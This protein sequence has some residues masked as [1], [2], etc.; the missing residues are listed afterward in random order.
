MPPAC[1][2][3]Q[4][5]PGIDPVSNQTKPKMQKGIPQERQL[6]LPFDMCAHT[7]AV[8]R[9]AYTS[10]YFFKV[11]EAD[12]ISFPMSALPLSLCYSHIYLCMFIASLKMCL[13]VYAGRKTVLALISVSFVICVEPQSRYRIL[14]YPAVVFCGR[15]VVKPSLRSQ[16]WQTS[17]VFLI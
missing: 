9:Y 1:Q 10:T 8:Y 13:N 6:R 17:S 5:R 12:G 11:Y 16:L 14:P 2:P 3:T 4:P 15:V 7:C